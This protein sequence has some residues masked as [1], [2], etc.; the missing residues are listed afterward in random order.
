MLRDLA[1][2]LLLSFHCIRMRGEK[3]KKNVDA[4]LIWSYEKYSYI[5]Y[6]MVFYHLSLLLIKALTALMGRLSLSVGWE[7]GPDHELK[8]VSFNPSFPVI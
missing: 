1:G 8:T 7:N 2:A 6:L 4:S 3:R 5:L